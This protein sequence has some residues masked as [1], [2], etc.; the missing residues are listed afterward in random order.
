MTLTCTRT[1]W[2]GVGNIKI[3]MINKPGTMRIWMKCCI[4]EVIIF[5][6]DIKEEGFSH[7]SDCTNSL[8]DSVTEFCFLLI[9]QQV[10]WRQGVCLYTEQG[11]KI[12][13]HCIEF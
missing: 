4:N 13:G 6:L 5:K 11:L 9:M 12:L 7:T 10:L 1:S 3:K 8:K 2:N